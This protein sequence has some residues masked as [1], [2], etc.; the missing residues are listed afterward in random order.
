MFEGIIGNER[1]KECLIRMV[2]RG[3]IGQSFLFSGPPGVGKSL[4][5]LSLARHIVGEQTKHHPDIRIYRPEGKIGFHSLDSMRRFSEDVY[6]ASLESNR[7]VFIIEEAD[8]MLGTSANAL[9]KTFEE[10]ADDAV[11]ILLSSAPES[12]LTTVVSRCRRIHFEPIPD[13]TLLNWLTGERGIAHETASKVVPFSGGS[14]A[15]ALRLCEQGSDPI[16][17]ATLALLAKP[18]LSFD[19]IKSYA[20]DASRVFQELK[21]ELSSAARSELMPDEPKQLSATQRDAIEKEIDGVVSLHFQ[22]EVDRLLQIVVSWYRDLHLLKSGGNASHIINKDQK[23]A[24]N[25]AD[26][27]SILPLEKIHDFAAEARLSIRRFTPVGS[28]LETFF[29]QV[30]R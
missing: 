24:L 4:F 14:A 17:E 13:D 18:S 20:D 16:R 5:A 29:L 23:P 9:L 10:P 11:I 22:E 15:E 7:K 6:L 12:L 19:A 25:G 27:K 1:V 28:A 2:E 3:K 8:R 26:T 21:D 30:T